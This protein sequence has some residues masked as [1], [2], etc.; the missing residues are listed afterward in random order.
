MG[1]KTELKRL[2]RGQKGK[3]P[4]SVSDGKQLTTWRSF[5]VRT[6]L[7]YV[8]FILLWLLLRGMFHDS[9]WWLTLMN[10][11]AVWLFVPIPIFVLIL[12]VGR[13]RKRQFAQKRPFPQKRTLLPLLIPLLTFIFLYGHLFWPNGQVAG[14][15][16]ENGRLL[17]VMTYN[18]LSANREFEAIV[19]E[20]QA[21][22]ADIVGLQ[23][24]TDDQILVLAR[25]LGD[26][27]PFIY[28]P[29]TGRTNNAT[30]LSKFPITEL[31]SID[32]PPRQLALH[33][34][35]TIDEQPVHLFVAH[36]MPNQLAQL[37]DEQALSDKARERFNFRLVEVTNL[38]FEMEN[39]TD[40]ILLMCDCNLT[41]TSHA[42]SRLDEFLDD[43][44]AE[45]GW[46]LGHTGF[47]P[48]W[49]W[50]THRID[51]VWHSEQFTAVSAT[52]GDKGGSDH[53]PVIATLLL[54]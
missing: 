37:D 16:E 41:D 4:S 36:L 25:L 10:S 52:R 7:A 34:I 45:A 39:V 53:L 20:I 54:K 24:V 42:Y 35:I 44:F 13:M 31:L 30:M 29:D 27:Y 19:D 21:A 50:A 23:E 11:Y 51:Y 43:S 28:R 32:F 33:A 8:G 26:D 47:I 18:I 17:T 1:S 2:A 5:F 22:N 40:P 48:F 49:P 12:V 9:I 38:Q 15:E 14:A 46:G 3:R 6:I